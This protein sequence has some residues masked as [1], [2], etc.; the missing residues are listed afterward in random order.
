MTQ[1]TWNKRRDIWPFYALLVSAIGFGALV[2]IFQMATL[3]KTSYYFEKSLYTIILLAFIFIFALF[4]FA[5]HSM[6][7]Q[8][9]KLGLVGVCLFV[10]VF[11]QYMWLQKGP[12]YTTLF[13]SSTVPGV[14]DSSAFNELIAEYPQ[15]LRGTH[16]IIFANN[17]N[18]LYSYINTRWS[19]SLYLTERLSRQAIEHDIVATSDAAKLPSNDIDTRIISGHKCIEK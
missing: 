3:G 1:T 5:L 11:S 7:K 14:V 10:F 4:S 8:F 19:G 16:D 2:Y 13:A 15:K 18:F 17:C 6:S 9:S 12:G